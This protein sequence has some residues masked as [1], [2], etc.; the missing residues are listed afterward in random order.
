MQNFSLKSAYFVD[1]LG[2]GNSKGG[3]FMGVDEER[4]VI[5]ETFHIPTTVVQN[6]TKEILHTTAHMWA[7]PFIAQVIKQTFPE[8]QT[9]YQKWR[10]NNIECYYLFKRQTT[11]IIVGPVVHFRFSLAHFTDE[12]RA[13]YAM[14]DEG[15][16]NH[17]IAKLP[18]ISDYD[19]LRMN[20]MIY[21]LIFQKALVV[22]SINI[23]QL[24]EQEMKAPY[25]TYQV[26]NDFLELVRAGKTKKVHDIFQQFSTMQSSRKLA[27]SDSVRNAKNISI[28]IFTLISREAIKA[29]MPE[30]Q[31]FFMGD[32]AIQAIEAKETTTDVIATLNYF[33]VEF[34]RQIGEGRHEYYSLPIVKTRQYIATNLYENI[35]L[36]A[37]STAIGLHPAYLSSLFK[38]EVGE[39]LKE[40]GQQKRIEESKRLLLNPNYSIGDI[41]KLL[42]FHDQSHFTKVFKKF[43]NYTPKQF[44]SIYS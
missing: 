12:I 24:E 29:G 3:I 2:V 42:H 13:T 7:Q 22:E 16:V 17:Y 44:R 14:I 33:V 38:K 43:T 19:M 21:A 15:K 23:E 39:T 28:T 40:F 37:I 31:A 27:T 11:T 32:R 20:K 10:V 8:E 18:I 34:T 30:D 36:T 35:S 4:L 41:A 6:T 26:E 9:S 25:L 5:E 1:K